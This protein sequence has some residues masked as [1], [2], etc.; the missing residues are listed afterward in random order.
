MCD[1]CTWHHKTFLVQLYWHM[2]IK[3]CCIILKSAARCAAAGM[4]VWTFR[5][6]CPGKTLKLHRQQVIISKG[7]EHRPTGHDYKG[8]TD[9]AFLSIYQAPTPTPTHSPTPQKPTTKT[10]PQQQ[11]CGHFDVKSVTDLGDQQPLITDALITALDPLTSNRDQ[12]YTHSFR[13]GFILHVRS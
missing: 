8:Q 1:E 13:G 3:L 5:G 6:S 2:A 9:T 7:D 10:W 11:V 4:R 12:R